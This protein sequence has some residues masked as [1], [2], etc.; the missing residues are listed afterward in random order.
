MS[1]RYKVFDEM[2]WPLPDPDLAWCLTHT[3]ERVTALEKMYCGAVIEA[4]EELIRCG[5]R[6]REKVRRVLKESIEAVGT[7]AELPV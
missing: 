7:D 3:P 5:R 1:K 2:T 4:Y 6:K